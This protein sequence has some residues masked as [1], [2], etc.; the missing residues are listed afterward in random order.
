MTAHLENVERQLA[1]PE[2][3]APASLAE[4]LSLALTA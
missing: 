1:Q 3:K 4:A 2:P